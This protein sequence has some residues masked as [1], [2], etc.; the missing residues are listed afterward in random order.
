[1]KRTLGE[2]ECTNQQVSLEQECIP[3]TSLKNY[4]PMH[5]LILQVCKVED[6]YQVLSAELNTSLAFLKNTRE[7]LQQ[8]QRELQS[9]LYSEEK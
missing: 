2:N 6:A 1:M 8:L 5:Q 4:L 9:E 7:S 3:A